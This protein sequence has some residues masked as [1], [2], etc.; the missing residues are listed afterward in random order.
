KES[1][2]ETLA[3][4][5]SANINM[6]A[7]AEMSPQNMYVRT[8]T[9]ATYIRENML[10]RSEAQTVYILTANRVCDAKKANPTLTNTNKRKLIGMPRNLPVPSIDRLPVPYWV[11]PF[12]TPVDIPVN[13]VRVPSVIGIG[14]TFKCATSSPFIKP[15]ARPMTIPMT[16]PRYVAPPPNVDSKAVID[17]AVDIAAAFATATIERSIA[18]I[19]N[20]IAMANDSNPIG[21]I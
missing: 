17:I 10:T 8:S 18:P 16:T 14:C 1:P 21:A 2:N 15:A 12:V 5:V 9:L 13:S 3:A 11:D 19:K 7:K 4:F 20:A 6:P